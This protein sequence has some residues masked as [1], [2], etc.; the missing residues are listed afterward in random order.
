MQYH[1][2]PLFLFLFAIACLPQLG[3]THHINQENISIPDYAAP[4]AN[5]SYHVTPS[6][7]DCDTTT[8]HQTKNL[9]E[10]GF[11]A[12]NFDAVPLSFPL[13]VVVENEY[14]SAENKPPKRLSILDREALNLWW[15]KQYG[16]AE[17]L[18]L[19]PNLLCK[20]TDC[21]YEHPVNTLHHGVYLWAF[22]VTQNCSAIQ[23]IYV[24]EG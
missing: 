6:H 23:E 9:L 18:V 19:L 12:K 15:Q 2:L 4:T 7:L 22:S 8:F 10:Q 13:R 24:Y 21:H 3:F 14:K 20:T 1:S 11:S 17:G 16:W 5:A